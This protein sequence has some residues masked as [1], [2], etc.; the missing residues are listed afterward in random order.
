MLEPRA[1]T[2]ATCGRLG[3]PPCANTGF[4]PVRAG[5][6]VTAGCSR[7]GAARGTA[8]RPLP[9]LPQR[10]LGRQ[11]APALPRLATTSLLLLLS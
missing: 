1:A 11:S 6:S 3:R 4:H 2:G 8:Q 7:P 9:L 10:W 5:R